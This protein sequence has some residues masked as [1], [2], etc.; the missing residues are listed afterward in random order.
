MKLTH[1]LPVVVFKSKIKMWISRCHPAHKDT[2]P[3]L[4]RGVEDPQITLK[5]EA[6]ERSCHVHPWLKNTTVP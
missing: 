4:G 1:T 2:Q 6:E 5:A 3:S